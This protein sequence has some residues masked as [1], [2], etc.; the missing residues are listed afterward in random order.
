MD[1][2][3]DSSKGSQDYSDELW[4]T[5]FPV[6]EIFIPPWRQSRTSA[7]MISLGKA[8]KILILRRTIPTTETGFISESFSDKDVKWWGVKLDWRSLN[9]QLGS[10]LKWFAKK[11]TV[12]LV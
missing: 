12:K 7:K 11:W 3:R 10:Q 5:H 2:Q 4:L 8:Q 9:A 6:D 1:R